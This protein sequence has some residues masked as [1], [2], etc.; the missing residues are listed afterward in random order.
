MKKELMLVDK[1]AIKF[2]IKQAEDR[3][4]AFREQIEKY[5]K[6]VQCLTG[7][8]DAWEMVLKYEEKETANGDRQDD[9]KDIGQDRKIVDESGE[10]K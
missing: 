1:N 5:N 9:S 2:A 3:M 10:S 6:E 8:I 7:A 4:R